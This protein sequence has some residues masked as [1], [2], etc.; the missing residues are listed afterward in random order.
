MLFLQSRL[1]ECDFPAK[2]TCP[3]LKDHHGG[4]RN[5]FSPNIPSK[6]RGTCHCQ[7]TCNMNWHYVEN[8]LF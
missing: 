6:Y 5:L 8:V 1:S 3:I 7:L 2:P 4:S